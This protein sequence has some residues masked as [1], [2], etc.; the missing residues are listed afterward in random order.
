MTVVR[1]RPWTLIDRLHR[2][3]D[4]AISA[5]AG[6]S[7]AAG[8]SWIPQVDIYEESERFVVL[9]DVPGVEP[10]D[11]RIT[12]DKGVLTIRGEK[13]A[14]EARAQQSEQRVERFR[15]TFVRQFTLPEGADL[16]AITAKHTHGVL[17]V[18]IP[19]QPKLQPRSIEVKAA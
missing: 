18:A 7:A 13:R 17:E 4:Q 11:I 19:K 2:E 14:R 15:G 6:E 9:A 5:Q 3:L 8:V 1:Y 10:T 16:D 12:A